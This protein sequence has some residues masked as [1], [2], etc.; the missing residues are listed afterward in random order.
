MKIARSTKTSQQGTALVVLC[1]VMVTT[2]LVI[3]GAMQLVS[4][5]TGLTNRRATVIN[6]MDFAQGGA[7]IACADLNYAVTNGGHPV[8]Y[9]LIH[10]TYPYTTN[11]SATTT[12]VTVFTRTITAPFTNQSVT[13]NIYLTNASSPQDAKI[14]GTATVLGVT[15][16]ATVHV[17]ISWAFPAAIISVNPGTT[18]TGVTKAVAQDGN[19]VINGDKTG[20]IVVDGGTAGKAVLANGRVNWNTNYVNPPSSAYSMSN[21]ATANQVP[22]YTTQGTSNTLFDIN[23]FLAVA[24][25]TSNGPSPGHNNHFTNFANFVT[26]VANSSPTNPLEGV[27][28]VDVTTTDANNKSYFPFT[29]TMAP[30]GINIKGTLL[31]NFLGSGWNPTT[32]KIVVTADFN[33]NAANLSGLNP[34]NPATYPSGYPPVYNNNA[35]NPTNIDISGRGFQNFN[36]DDDLPAIIYTIGVLDMHGNA[37]ISGVMYTPSY[38]EIENKSGGQTQYIKGALIMGYGIYYENVNQKPG[39]TSI[40]SFDQNTLD[41]LSTI[42]TAGKQVTVNYWE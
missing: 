14:T 36:S 42:G 33:V 29:P 18:E 4:G 24:D 35:K 11:T 25:L 34:T 12:N 23:R 6:A 20:P 31:F 7:V 17:K 16:S 40:I 3:A 27:I 9:N 19:V 8:A 22:D 15:Q 10:G 30:H 1:I 2:V 5:E 13:A 32:E 26:A 21:Y 39:S 41:S 38:M 28:A 37:N